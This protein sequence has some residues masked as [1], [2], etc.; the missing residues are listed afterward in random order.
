MTLGALNH[1]GSDLGHD[2]L[3]SRGLTVG[4]FPFVLLA[5]LRDGVDAHDGKS[6]AGVR[7]FKQSTRNANPANMDLYKW[8]TSCETTDSRPHRGMDT[9][10]ESLKLCFATDRFAKEHTMMISIGKE[11]ENDFRNPL[12]LLSDCHRRIERF[13]NCLIVISEQAKGDKFNDLQRQEFE[14]A[15]RYF[16]EAAPKHTLDEEESLFPRLRACQNYESQAVFA[17]LDNLH[18]DHTEAEKQHRRVDELGSKWLAEGSL[19]LDDAQ[20]FLELLRALRTTYEKHIAVEDD[21]VFRLA[22]R[23]LHPSELETIG[24]EMAARRGIVI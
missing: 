18:L 19:P 2:F 11:L 13:L 16:R 4:Q 21:E 6:Y 14:V 20:N 3:V 5:A 12:G 9:C 15:L 1:N 10:A 17:L 24:Q 8:H 23:V 22:G 7:S